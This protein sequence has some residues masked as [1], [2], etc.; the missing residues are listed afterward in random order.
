MFFHL[1][2]SHF[3]DLFKVVRAK[4][5][6]RAGLQG[7]PLP[8]NPQACPAPGRHSVA[9]I[10]CLLILV[11]GPGWIRS[12]G[13]YR[14][15][16]FLFLRIRFC[17][18]PFALFYFIFS[19]LFFKATLYFSKRPKVAGLHIYTHS[20]TGVIDSGTDTPFIKVRL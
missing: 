20:Y 7:A 1:L 8:P 19:L 11:S 9:A 10:R 4:S 6:L 12:Q 13:R 17:L 2:L 16:I 14:P 18:L 15:Q 5:P 3:S